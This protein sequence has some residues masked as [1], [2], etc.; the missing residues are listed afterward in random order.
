MAEKA[1]KAAEFASGMISTAAGKV[2]EGAKAGLGYSTRAA[3]EAKAAT[4][5]GISAAGKF[6]YNKRPLTVAKATQ[7]IGEDERTLH[8]KMDQ[9]Q[10]SVD[11]VLLAVETYGP[12]AV[13][14]TEAS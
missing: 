3:A 9:L 7:M 2:F 14:T 12:E 10:A 6:A 4:V 8:Q 1:R 13:S 5:K 11:Q